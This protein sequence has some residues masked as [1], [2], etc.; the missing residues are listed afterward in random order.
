MASPVIIGTG[1]HLVA[2]AAETVPHIPIGMG[3][4]EAGFATGS[5]I[6]AGLSYLGGSCR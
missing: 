2:H 6:N 1:T 3:V 5:F 4:V